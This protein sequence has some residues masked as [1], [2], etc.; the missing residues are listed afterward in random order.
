M[1]AYRILGN[2]TGSP[3]HDGDKN[4]KGLYR[5]EPF[6]GDSPSER[7][8][9]LWYKYCNDGIN[10]VTDELSLNEMKELAKLS[11]EISG[12]EFE[13]VYVSHEKTCPHNSV[14]YGIDIYLT[15]DDSYL[16]SGIDYIRKINEKSAEKINANILFD[17]Y[18]DAKEFFDEA[19]RLRKEN[20]GYY[21][22]G[23][24]KIAYI[25]KVL[26]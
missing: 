4:Y 1:G 18:D 12:E 24:M 13:V 15:Y 2:V 16:W 6:P 11:S 20:P 17:N 21:E 23:E 3:S 25:Y 9:E 19:E 10:G 14:F 7:M 5:S 22:S 26:D 8:L